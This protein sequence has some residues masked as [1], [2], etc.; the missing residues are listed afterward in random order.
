MTYGRIKQ[1]DEPIDTSLTM[2][3]AGLNSV[4]GY[5]DTYYC[6]GRSLREGGGRAAGGAQQPRAELGKGATAHH[7]VPA[8]PPPTPGRPQLLDPSLFSLSL[9]L[10]M[11]SESRGPL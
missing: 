5:P 3:M 6:R 9:L 1:T 8:M 10:P 11:L 4:P 2:R 7:P